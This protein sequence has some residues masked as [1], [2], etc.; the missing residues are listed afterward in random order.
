MPKPPRKGH[1]LFQGQ[2]N[3]IIPTTENGKVRTKGEYEKP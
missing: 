3:D 2:N 1:S